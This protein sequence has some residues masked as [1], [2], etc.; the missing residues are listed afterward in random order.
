MQNFCSESQQ[1][2]TRKIYEGNRIPFITAS[3]GRRIAEP[4]N[5]RHPRP[6]AHKS[7]PCPAAQ[8]AHQS[9]ASGCPFGPYGTD[10]A[11]GT[12]GHFGRRHGLRK[13]LQRTAVSVLV[14]IATRRYG[15]VSAWHKRSWCVAATPE[16]ARHAGPPN[17]TPPPPPPQGCI[18][19]WG[20]SP[21]PS[22]APSLCPTTV[23]LTPSASFN[24]I[25]N[26]R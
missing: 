6:Q 3:G 19:R 26:R 17:L 20:G 11:R 7:L 14:S 23:S 12:P 15:S 8:T 25:C 16:A 10:I 24:G 22:R 21:S 4:E 2:T 13:G 5:S 9:R 18:G 1:K